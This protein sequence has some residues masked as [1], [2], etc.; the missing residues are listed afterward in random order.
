MTPLPC[1]LP[2]LY[3]GWHAPRN[4]V[5]FT[6]LRHM[7]PSP[8]HAKQAL[9]QEVQ[10]PV[11]WTQQVHGASV[12]DA[13]LQASIEALP[14]ADASITTRVQL[15]LVISTADCLPV[16]FATQ[17]GSAVGAA[18]AGWRGL[19]AGVLENTAHA[20][21][22]KRPGVALM[23]HIGPAISPRAFEVGQ[24]VLDAFVSRDAQ[25]SHA[26]TTKGNGKYWGNL[27]LLARQRLAKAG[28]QQITGGVHCTVINPWLFYSFRGEGKI[29][30][31][32][33]SVIWRVS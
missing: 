27:Y 30:D 3:A 18:H 14:Q 9:Q 24:D 32:L 19:A 20:L 13:D 8:E 21:Q 29:V 16:F 5:A 6:T 25:A 15:P 11:V 4:I 10:Q 33:R 31:H 22:T 23:A 26:F 12:W 1:V 28:V 2:R 7:L 17:D